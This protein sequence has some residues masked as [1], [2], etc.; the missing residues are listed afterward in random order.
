LGW[1]GAGGWRRRTGED[2]QRVAQGANGQRDLVAESL[3]KLFS[4][5]GCPG[6]Q[7]DLDW[8]L[9]AL[10]RLWAGKAEEKDRVASAA[11]RSQRELEP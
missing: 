2:A 5:L 9:P 10:V 3:V 8:W 11:A 7:A 4:D 1:E 6:G